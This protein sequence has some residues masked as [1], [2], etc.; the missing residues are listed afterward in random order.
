MLGEFS[1]FTK[2]E[3][4]KS[5]DG[6]GDGYSENVHLY[7]ATNGMW[8]INSVTANMAAGI[9]TGLVYG[10]ATNSGHF[11]IRSSATPLDLVWKYHNGFA[12]EAAPLLRVE[13]ISQAE[14]MYEL[15]QN[16]VDKLDQERCHATIAVSISGTQGAN[17][18]G[19]YAKAG[20]GRKSI[21]WETETTGNDIV[22]DQDDARVTRTN[23]SSWGTQVTEAF[24]T[25]VTVSVSVDNGSSNYLAIGVLDAVAEWTGTTA[26]SSLSKSRYYYADGTLKSESEGKKDVPALKGEGL[27]LT[28]A[29]DMTAHTITFS[30]DGT[31]IGVL[32]DVPTNAR[33]FATFGGSNQF[34]TISGGSSSSG[35]GGPEKFGAPYFTLVGREDTH[36]YRGSNGAWNIGTTRA[37]DE[38]EPGWVE[39]ARDR[40]SFAPLNLEVCF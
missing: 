3:K 13:S 33:V 14:L 22:I 20:A 17:L 2:L 1:V 39:S 8:Y 9:S 5:G 16:L 36:L 24:T 29:I 31:E 4:G 25:D 38:G 26:M 21:G 6:S 10:F 40:P 32:Q 15:P 23:S 30:R 7:R 19:V 34:V 27:E 11:S 12:W 37:M 28:M 35:D 18:G